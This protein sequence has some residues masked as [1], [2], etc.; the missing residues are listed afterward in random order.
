M[1]AIVCV[2]E[3]W[4]IG[5]NGELL[6][7]IKDDLKRFRQLTL[8]KS[9]IMG[10][11]T[12]ESLPGGKGLPS[13]HNVVLTTNRDYTAEN[14]E[15]IHFPVEAVFAA[16]EDAAVIGGEQIYRLLLPLCEKVYVTKVFAAPEADAF[17]PDL[18]ADPKWQVES[19]KPLEQTPIQNKSRYRVR[20]LPAAGALL[21]QEDSEEQQMELL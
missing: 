20:S 1:F 12:L 13:R 3:N 16:G 21:R 11:K 18:D 9:V 19:V 15:I 4:G 2:S 10:R 8:D 17:F 6:F 14:A 5:K 7:H